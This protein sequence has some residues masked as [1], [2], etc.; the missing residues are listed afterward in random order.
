MSDRKTETESKIEVRSEVILALLEGLRTFEVE[1][2]QILGRQGISQPGPGKWYPLQSLI[3]A[4]A[5]ITTLMTPTSLYTMG[6][7]IAENAKATDEILDFEDFT[8]RLDEIY[9]RNHRGGEIGH[10][11]MI[12]EEPRVVRVVSD[13]PYPCDFDRGVLFGFARRYPPEPGAD[14]FVDHDSDSPCRKRGDDSC[15]YRIRW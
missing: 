11:K 7:K 2:L 15:T 6:S 3:G 9:H 13:I 10:Y 12:W 4:W 5:E 1:A 14:I 8:R